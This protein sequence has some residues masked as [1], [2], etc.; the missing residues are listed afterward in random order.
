LVRGGLGFVELAQ[1]FAGGGEDDGLPLFTAFEVAV[2]VGDVDVAARRTFGMVDADDVAGG[3]G[4]VGAVLE[5]VGRLHLVAVGR[6]VEAFEVA[7]AVEH[8]RAQG[9]EVDR[10][11]VR[12]DLDQ[13]VGV[14]APDQQ[15]ALGVGVHRLH[16]FGTGDVDVVFEDVGRVGQR[17][18]ASGRHA[19]GGRADGHERA[20]DP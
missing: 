18:A 11:A 7:C 3:A 12:V 14:V 8:V 15:V 19:G 4:G 6:R 9:A 2:V 16:L 13:I 1:V 10:V 17:G 5:S 20:S